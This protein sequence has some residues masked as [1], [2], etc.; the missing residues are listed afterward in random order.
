ML[1]AQRLEQAGPEI[2]KQSHAGP[3][4]HDRGEHVGS[5]RVV[6]EVSAGLIRDRVRQEIAHCALKLLVALNVAMGC[7]TLVREY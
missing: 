2:V 4:L 7:G 1:D 6:E 3:S 5:A